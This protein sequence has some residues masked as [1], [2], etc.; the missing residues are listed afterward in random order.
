MTQQSTT[1]EPTPG[2]YPKAAVGPFAPT[3]RRWM[4]RTGMALVAM[5]ATT[6]AKSSG[7]ASASR[8]SGYMPSATA[9]HQSCWPETGVYPA[10]CCYLA[11]PNSCSGTGSN[12]T[13]PSGYNKKTWTCCDGGGQRVRYCGECTTGSTCSERAHFH[14]SET[15]TQNPTC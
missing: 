14:C 12:F 4:T 13:C 5:V 10:G 6:M 9:N 11:C 2:S 1:L 15:W 3:R 7:R 8:S